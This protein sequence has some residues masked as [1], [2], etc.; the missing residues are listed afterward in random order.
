MLR[1]VR[2]RSPRHAGLMPRMLD[3]SRGFRDILGANYF[4]RSFNSFAV[5]L[6]NGVLGGVGPATVGAAD[7][8]TG[9]AS[10]AGF[11]TLNGVASE[12]GL[13][14]AGALGAGALIAT[15]I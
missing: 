13:R 1:K 2:L 6:A 9:V 10:F 4:S 12:T 15:G 8:F 14:R 5:L 7:F 11:F 3:Q